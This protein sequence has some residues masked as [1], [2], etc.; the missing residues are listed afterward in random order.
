MKY[1][2]IND[3]RE[4][5]AKYTGDWRYNLRH[6]N[7]T[8]VWTNDGT[9]F[10]GIWHMDK[11][12]RGT[13]TFGSSSSGTGAVSYEGEFK[14][15]LFHGKGKLKMVDGSLYDGVFEAGNC[16]KFGKMLYKDGNIYFGEMNE[17]KRHGAG[18]LVKPS[19]ERIEGQFEN[20]MATGI[21]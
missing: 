6:G 11:R 18:I 2:M 16:V 12:V 5:I 15:D 9:K 21:S 1:V 17:F 19:G 13:L 14:D 4:D 10:E 20:D 7:G 3:G 8:M